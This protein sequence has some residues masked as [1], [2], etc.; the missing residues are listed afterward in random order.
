MKVRR[1]RSSGT[2]G[3]EVLVRMNEVMKTEMPTI[4]TC[5]HTIARKKQQTNGQTG[6]PTDRQTN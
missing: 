2:E 4:N 1:G 6:K 3:V 5:D